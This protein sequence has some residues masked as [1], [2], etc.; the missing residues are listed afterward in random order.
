MQYDTIIRSLAQANN[1]YQIFIDYTFISDSFFMLEYTSLYVYVP[2][3]R[4]LS[5]LYSVL[6]WES[7]TITVV[8]LS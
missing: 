5:V 6:E 4:L 7:V 2:Y 3:H 8:T 1:Y